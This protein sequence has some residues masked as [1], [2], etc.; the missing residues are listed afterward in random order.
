[1]E[2]SKRARVVEKLQGLSRQFK[3]Y[4]LMEMV[5]AAAADPFEKIKGLIEEMITKLQNEANEE[6]TQK[7]FCD[8]ENSKSKASKEEKTMK[9]DKLQARL[10]KATSTKA[11]LEQSVKELEGEVAELDK[12]DA[13][14]TKLRQEENAENTKAAADFKEAAEAVTEAISVLREYYE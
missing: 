6:A 9:S 8:E 1:M 2:D 4:A 12:G 14:A 7:A 11:E 10:D 5:S 3:S 13:E